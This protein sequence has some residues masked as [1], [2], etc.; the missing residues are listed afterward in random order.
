MIK[1]WISI[2]LPPWKKISH[3]SQPL[4]CWKASGAKYKLQG[5]AKRSLQH[6]HLFKEV[7]CTSGHSSVWAIDD[8]F[9]FHRESGLWWEADIWVWEVWWSHFSLTFRGRIQ[10]LPTEA[11]TM[12]EI[13]CKWRN[14]WNRRSLFGKSKIV[15]RMQR[16]LPAASRCFKIQEELV[17]FFS[18]SLHLVFTC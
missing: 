8:N 15:P 11:L 4:F 12:D 14:R 6:L 16:H 10:I 18:S 1:H 7:I 9:A 17:R 3:S 5:E 2:F 13:W